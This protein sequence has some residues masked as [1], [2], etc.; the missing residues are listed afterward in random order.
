MDAELLRKTLKTFKLT[1][2]NPKL[3]KITT[4]IYLDKIFNLA[5][6]LFKP[7]TSQNKSEIQF[8]GLISGN[9]RVNYHMLCI[10][11]HL[12]EYFIKKYTIGLIVTLTFEGL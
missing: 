2:A 4:I 9:F 10:L 1:T 6:F 3:M 8:F 5:T 11:F 12:M 7:K